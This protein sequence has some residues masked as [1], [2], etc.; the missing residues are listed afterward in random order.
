MELCIHGINTVPLSLPGGGP[1]GVGG[2]NWP[3]WKDLESV[4]EITQRNLHI[5]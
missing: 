3:E 4:L 2:G 1:V 5:F